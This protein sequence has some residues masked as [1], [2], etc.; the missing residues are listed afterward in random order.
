MMVGMEDDGSSSREI[1]RE[2]RNE[3]RLNDGLE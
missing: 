3:Q 1:A 2:K